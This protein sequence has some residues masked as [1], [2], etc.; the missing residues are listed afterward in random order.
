M[1]SR[2]RESES[3]PI[4]WFT[5]QI[6]A[7]TGA[8]TSVQE[9]LM[10]VPCVGRDPNIWAILYHL[11]TISKHLDTKLNSL[12]GLKLVPIWDSGFASGNWTYYATIPTPSGQC[13]FTLFIL[14][15]AYV[16]F[17]YKSIK[18]SSE[19]G[20]LIRMLL[21]WVFVLRDLINWMTLNMDTWNLCLESACA[22]NIYGLIG[23][24]FQIAWF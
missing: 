20:N 17:L 1:K 12:P 19:V 9:F 2:I 10:G 22:T 4:F 16:C 3:S 24:C 13:V 6:P 14:L 8:N 18:V 7:I 21:F 5:T 11:Q 23:F 15:L